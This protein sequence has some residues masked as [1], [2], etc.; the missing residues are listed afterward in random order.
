MCITSFWIGPWRG[1]SPYK[2]LLSTPS[3]HRASIRSVF[4]WTIEFLK[5][6]LRSSLRQLRNFRSLRTY[7]RSTCTQKQK[8]QL[9]RGQLVP[10]NRKSNLWEVDLYT[11]IR[12]STSRQNNRL[13]FG[14]NG[15]RRPMALCLP[16]QNCYLHS[17]L[18]MIFSAANLAI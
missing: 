6:L 11:T 18:S 16:Q 8:Q 5:V 14:I 17:I 4:R 2:T 15:K 7:E 13:R 3:P 10:K 1:A 12:K 9:M